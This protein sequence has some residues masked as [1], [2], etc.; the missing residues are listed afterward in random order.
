MDP[1]YCGCLKTPI[2]FSHPMNQEY[3]ITR[4]K[5]YKTYMRI[6]RGNFKSVFGRWNVL[7]ER[8][9]TKEFKYFEVNS[10]VW[11]II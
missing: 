7:K 11:I 5:I 8:N 2:Y 3:I 1:I 9:V 6:L 4:R 10:I